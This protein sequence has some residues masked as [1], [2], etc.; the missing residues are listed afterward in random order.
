MIEIRRFMDE[1]RQMLCKLD[2]RCIS[3]W[4]PH[5]PQQ[6]VEDKVSDTLFRYGRSIAALQTASEGLMM[7][8]NSGAALH[9][10]CS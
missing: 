10:V 4:N 2:D 3:S 1:S 6:N 7:W 5:P 8:D 9:C